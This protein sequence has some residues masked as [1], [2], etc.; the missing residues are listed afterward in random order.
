MF[1][2]GA[3]RAVRLAYEVGIGGI[4]TRSAH[5]F[6]ASLDTNI[7]RPFNFLLIVAMSSSSNHGPDNQGQDAHGENNQSASTSSPQS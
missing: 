4:K 1:F 7:T 3:L 2:L 5:S 6:L